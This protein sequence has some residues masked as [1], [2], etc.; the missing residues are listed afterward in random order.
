ML[1]SAIFKTFQQGVD[2]ILMGRRRLPGCSLEIS[3]IPADTAGKQAQH[4][5]FKSKVSKKL[6]T[7]KFGLLT[8]RPAG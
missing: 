4:L 8:L 6:L 7:G 1:H 3:R 2:P 5:A